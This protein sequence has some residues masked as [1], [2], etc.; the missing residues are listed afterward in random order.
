MNAIRSILDSH[1]AAGYRQLAAYE[2]DLY[3]IYVAARKTIEDR[4]GVYVSAP[5]PV[6]VGPRLVALADKLQEH[7]ADFEARYRRSAR[8]ATE[9]IA[10][11]FYRAAI[12][13]LG[14]HDPRVVGSLDTALLRQMLDDGY[15]HIAGATQKMSMAAVGSLRR[16]SARVMREAAMTGETRVAISERLYHEA[17][18]P[19]FIFRGRNGRIWDSGAYFEMLGRTMLHNNA[20]ETYLTA[21]AANGSDIVAVSYSGDPCA[22]C[23]RWQGRLL[24]ITGQSPYPTIETAIADGLCHPSCTHRIVAVPPAI[25][26]ASFDVRGRPRAAAAGKDNP[27]DPEHAF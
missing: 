8:L 6:F 27:E 25:A 3:Q 17:G 7:F 18:G 23:A 15:A 9:K 22:A 11:A 21:C 5:R 14:I 20:R 4:I 10:E 16:I 19:S 26:Q 13:D 2:H 24:S 1:A 12:A